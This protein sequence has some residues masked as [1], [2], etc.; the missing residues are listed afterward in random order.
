MEIYGSDY[1][2]P[3]GTGVRDYIH[4][5]DLAN[6][7]VAAL[8]HLRRGGASAVLNCGYGHGYSVLEVVDAVRRIAPKPFEIR[9]SGRRPGDPPSLVANTTRMRETLDWRPHYDNLDLTVSH[10]LMWEQAL[11]ERTS[12]AKGKRR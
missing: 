1:P 6:C 10:A 7:H 11:L 4:V 3:D 8:T 5:K 9:L 2:T 12:D